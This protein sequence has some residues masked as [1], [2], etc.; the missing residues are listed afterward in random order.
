MLKSISVLIG[1]YKFKKHKTEVEKTDLNYN[2]ITF[3]LS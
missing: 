1:G 2:Q 3:I